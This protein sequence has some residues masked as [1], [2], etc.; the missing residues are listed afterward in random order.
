M[1]L[2]K[3]LGDDAFPYFEYMYLKAIH[4]FLT[5][6]WW[7]LQGGVDEVALGDLV[8]VL[9]ML[10]LDQKARRDLFLLAQSGQA[11]RTMPTRS[12]GSS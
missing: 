6:R 8:R 1:G 3:Y 11:G 9:R 7:I 10:E 2:L 4:Y 12:C 5:Q